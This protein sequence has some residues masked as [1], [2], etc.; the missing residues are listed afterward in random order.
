[1]GVP[2]VRPG[3]GSG[4]ITRSDDVPDPVARFQALGSRSSTHS[5]LPISYSLIPNSAE[6]IAP[7]AASSNRQ[8]LS[9]TPYSLAPIPT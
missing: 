9:P 1:M 8:P 5:P 4:F 7:R 3:M 2:P 6:S